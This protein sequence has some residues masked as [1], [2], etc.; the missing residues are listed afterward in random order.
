MGDCVDADM[1]ECGKANMRKC[2][3]ARM[4]FT[5]KNLDIWKEG[6]ELVEKIYQLTS[7]FPEK[8]K[9][10]II[11]Q[12]KR[13]VVSVPTNI[14]EGAAR[15]SIKEFIQFLYIS[16]GSLS[17]LE[18]LLFISYK[19]NYFD[20]KVSNDVFDK[21]EKLRRMILNFIKYQK[22]KLCESK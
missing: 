11:S 15:Q 6:I 7:T 5:H 21:V 12:M 9:Y 1:R 3:D 8:E 4:S 13:S 10:G 14:A 2:E 20:E 19:L 17:E 18:T 16:L 22:K